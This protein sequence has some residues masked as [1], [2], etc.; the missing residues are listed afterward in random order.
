MLRGGRRS[1]SVRWRL[2]ASVTRTMPLLPAPYICFRNT[3]PGVAGFAER[4]PE[5]VVAGGAC[6]CDLTGGVRSLR[7]GQGRTPVSRHGSR[8]ATRGHRPSSWPSQQTCRKGGKRANCPRA[9]G[10]RRAAWHEPF[11]TLC[12]ALLW[13]CTSR[14]GPLRDLLLHLVESHHGDC[15]PFVSVVEDDAALNVSFDFQGRNLAACSATHLERLDS[16]VSERSGAS[17]G[18]TAGGGLAWLEAILRLAD[19]RR[20]EWE[21]DH[22]GRNEKHD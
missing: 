19:H 5:V 21:E 2:T 9:A 12:K 15:R 16:G 20:S 6:W 18:V 7:P 17:A 1:I 13:V 8:V 22:L 10:Y 3:S 14:A 4:L 11:V